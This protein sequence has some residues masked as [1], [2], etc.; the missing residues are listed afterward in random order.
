MVKHVTCLDITGRT[1][2]E[3]TEL[4]ERARIDSVESMNDDQKQAARMLLEAFAAFVDAKVTPPKDIRVRVSELV[5][6]G[7]DFTGSN[8]D[9]E[10]IA[11]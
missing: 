5:A 8:G 6:R 2:A 9:Q 4:R 11:A 7:I 3:L 1:R 10:Q